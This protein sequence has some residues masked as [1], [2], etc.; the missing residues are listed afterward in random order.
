MAEKRV[1]R[2]TAVSEAELSLVHEQLTKKE[3]MLKE[4][5]AAMQRESSWL[6]EQANQLRQEQENL[7]RSRREGSTPVE[8]IMRELRAEMDPFKNLINQL[9]EQ[10]DDIQKHS[11][12][13]VHRRSNN[14]ESQVQPMVDDEE[15]HDT[16]AE[17]KSVNT[18]SL[19]LKDAIESVP[20]YDGYRIPI[21]QYARACERARDMI[22]PASESA[23][24]SLI[25]NKL[26]GH[27]FQAVE[28]AEIATVTQLI[29]R[30]KSIFAPR[31]SLDQY[32]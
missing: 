6:Q 25:I 14:L 3:Q 1:T 17:I 2:Q 20:R 19:R 4:Q 24:V 11:R 32:R 15:P 26:Q 31:K 18:Q 30:L 8:Q 12:D 5:A 9:K 7:E 28:D 23:L 21:Y 16:R 10:V 29:D 13:P 27:A 22:S